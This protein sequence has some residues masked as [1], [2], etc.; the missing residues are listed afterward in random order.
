MIEEELTY[1]KEHSVNYYSMSHY[2][3]NAIKEFSDSSS[4][5]QLQL[6]EALGHFYI[7]NLEDISQISDNLN[8]TVK[9]TN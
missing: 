6:I 3:R 4:V 9:R 2:I 8:N 1:I 5:R 7:D